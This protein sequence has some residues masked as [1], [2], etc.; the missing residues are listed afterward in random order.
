MS[1]SL[2][3]YRRPRPYIIDPKPMKQGRVFLRYK[4]LLSPAI[5]GE[6]TGMSIRGLQV[7]AM[8]EGPGICCW[9][10]FIHSRLSYAQL[11]S[12]SGAYCSRR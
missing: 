6:K 10:R 9:V 4:V 8:A 7:G 2:R 12:W 11:V 1:M 5:G 3:V